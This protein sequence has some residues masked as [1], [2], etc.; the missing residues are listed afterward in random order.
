MILTQKISGKIKYFLPHHGQATWEWIN[1]E[2]KSSPTVLDKSIMLT[3]TIDSH[4]GRACASMEVPIA[5]IQKI[6]SSRMGIDL[7][8]TSGVG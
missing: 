8:R 1:K 7:L 5:F 3:A 4:K 6:L 2:D